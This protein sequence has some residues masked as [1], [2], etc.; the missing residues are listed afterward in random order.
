M[1][2]P[3]APF[4]GCHRAQEFPS[5]WGRRTAK[6]TSRKGFD[7]CQSLLLFIHVIV[8][9]RGRTGTIG[10][11][12]QETAERAGRP[13]SCVLIFSQRLPLLI[14][15]NAD[16]NRA[17]QHWQHQHSSCRPGRAAG[18]AL[19]PPVHF[20]IL[21]KFLDY[22]FFQS[23]FISVPQLSIKILY[24][25]KIKRFLQVLSHREVKINTKIYTQP[26]SLETNK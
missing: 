23:P 21:D 3:L 14:L 26:K 18:D 12:G 6:F 15:S 13:N 4:S 5:A 7:L 22:I 2:L 17:E 9:S 24:S 16:N 10:R 25:L 8:E 20:L 11:A 1:M 19:P